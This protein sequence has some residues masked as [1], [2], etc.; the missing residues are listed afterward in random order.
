MKS[1]TTKHHAFTEYRKI[2]KTMSDILKEGLDTPEERFL[3][4]EL[5]GKETEEIQA[6]VLQKIS[7]FV[8]GSKIFK[9]E[10]MND[11]F[12]INPE[13][14]GKAIVERI[15]GFIYRQMSFS[16]HF[17]QTGPWF[18][19]EEYND[20]HFFMPDVVEMAKEIMKYISR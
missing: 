7:E 18:V 20:P 16:E 11:K 3:R 10:Y 19:W 1:K 15:Q 4:T 8:R 6:L 5:K 12:V 17:M 2:G 13:K 14:L 9:P